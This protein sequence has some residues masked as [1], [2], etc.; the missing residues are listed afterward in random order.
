MQNS[1]KCASEKS[2]SAC[3]IQQVIKVQLSWG[4]WQQIGQMTDS[5]KLC[6]KGNKLKYL[7][8]VIWEVLSLLVGTR[9]FNKNALLWSF[10]CSFYVWFIWKK[11]IPERWNVACMKTGFWL[12]GNFFIYRLN[13]KVGWF[14]LYNHDNP[15]A[16]TRAN[17][18]DFSKS[19]F[20]H[21]LMK[22]K[23]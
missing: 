15:H 10:M 8:L 22:T 11:V 5:Y 3:K 21:V 23:Y 13:T 2:Y 9:R 1:W 20:E 12:N 14:F 16:Q 6:C 4:C 17:K 18:L 7:W 19:C